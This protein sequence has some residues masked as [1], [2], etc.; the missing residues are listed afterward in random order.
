MTNFHKYPTKLL[1][2]EKVYKAHK[3]QYLSDCSVILF[4][5]SYICSYVY[6]F[7]WTGP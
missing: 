2:K 6:V 3:L 5:P 7:D 1:K 4:K